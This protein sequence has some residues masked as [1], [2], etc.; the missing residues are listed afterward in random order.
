MI[1]VAFNKE[2]PKLV[3]TVESKTRVAIGNAGVKECYVGTLLDYSTDPVTVKEEHKEQVTAFDA[4][5]QECPVEI[6][7]ADEDSGEDEGDGG[8]DDA[9]GGTFDLDLKYSAEPNQSGFYQLLLIPE[10]LMFNEDMVTIEQGCVYFG[11]HV[12]VKVEDLTLAQDGYYIQDIPSIGG[13]T[14]MI[15]DE[16]AIALVM[17]NGGFEGLTISIEADA[18]IATLDDA[19][20]NAFEM[21]FV[22]GEDLP[23]SPYPG[24]YTPEE[25]QS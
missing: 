23:N 6:T 22:F 1:K 24:E 4:K 11:E 3:F 16:N 9:E 14:L 5:W 15:T 17:E 18:G 20:S 25:P 19:T 10:D 13:W 8:D 7:E 21:N 12:T 2:N